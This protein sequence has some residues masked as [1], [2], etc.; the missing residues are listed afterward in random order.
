MNREMK[1]VDSR[2][3]KIQQ[4][5]FTNWIND[6][7]RG[8]LTKPDSPVMNLMTDFKDGIRLIDLM[9][10]LSKTKLSTNKTPKLKAHCLENLNAALKHIKKEG[11]TLVNIDSEDIHNGNEK[12]LLGLVWT[13]IRHYQIRS[14]GKG[15]STKKAMLMRVGAVIPEYNLQNLTTNW[16]DG[17]ALCGLVNSIKPG[18]CPNH[19]ELDPENGL[20]NCRLGMELAEENFNIPRILDPEDMNSKQID[21]LSMMT[22]LSYLLSCCNQGLLEWLQRQLPEFEITNLASDWNDGI[23]LAALIDKLFNVFPDRKDLDPER[24]ESNWDRLLPVIA[25]AT[26]VKCPLTAKQMS[27]PDI[28]ELSM[29]AFLA[30]LRYA[31][32]I[33]TPESFSFKPPTATACIG[34]ELRLQVQVMGPVDDQLTQDISVSGQYADGTD[35]TVK[36]AGIEDRSLTYGVAADQLGKLSISLKY[37]GENI[38]RSPFTVNVESLF[39]IEGLVELLN[40]TPRVGCPVMFKIKAKETPAPDTNINI[41]AKGPSQKLKTDISFLKENIFLCTLTPDEEGEY[42]VSIDANGHQIDGSPFC[43]N[44]KHLFELHIEEDSCYYVGIPFSITATALG[45]VPEGTDL[46]IAGVGQNGESIQGLCETM[47]KSRTFKLSLKP[48]HSGSFQVSV[49]FKDTHILG[50][51]FNLSVMDVY[52]IDSFL[53]PQPFTLGNSVQVKIVPLGTPSVEGEISI[54]GKGPTSSVPGTVTPDDPGFVCSF[55]PSETG[56]AEISVKFLNFHVKGSP[57]VLAVED[58]FEFQTPPKDETVTIGSSVEVVLKA[59]GNVKDGEDPYVVATDQSRSPQMGVVQKNED[60]TYVCSFTP[61]WIGI[62]EIEVKQRESVLKGTPI[63]VSVTHLLE[64]ADI[65]P[66]DISYSVGAPVKYLLKPLGTL[67]PDAEVQILGMGPKWE[68]QGT[69]IRNPDSSFQCSISPSE[70]G[71]LKVATKYMDVHVRGSPFSLGV[72]DL[73]YVGKVPPKFLAK[74]DEP[75]NF[76]VKSL[77]PPG[78]NTFTVISKGPSTESAGEIV[79]QENDSFF[80][81]ITPREQ[82]THTIHV[83]MDGQD[84]KGSP[85]NVDVVDASQCVFDKLPPS[86]VHIG[87]EIEFTVNTAKAGTGDLTVEGEVEEGEG[88]VSLVVQETDKGNYS[89]KVTGEAVGFSLIRILFSGDPIPGTPIKMGVVDAEKCSVIDLPSNLKVGEPVRF[90]LN[91]RGSGPGNPSV[92]FVGPD[93][94]YEPQITSNGDGTFW[95]ETHDLIEIGYYR[96]DIKFGERLIPGSP[97]NLSIEPAPTADQCHVTGN[98]LNKAVAGRPAKFKVL[99]TESGL[100]EREKLKVKVV[101]VSGGKKGKVKILDNKDKTYSAVYLCTHT[102]GY[103]IHVDF[104]DQPAPGSPFRINIVEGANATHVRAYGPALEPRKVLMSHTPQEFHVNA[105]K[106]GNGDLVVVIRGHKEDPKIYITDE[107]D[108]IFSVK[109]EVLGSGKYFAN[110]WWGNAHIP[111]S[112]FPLRI[113]P[114]PNPTMVKVHGPGIQ[115]LVNMQNAAHFTIETKE[116]GVGTLSVRVN[117]VKDAFTVEARP[118]SEVHPRTLLARYNPTCPGN[119]NIAIRWHGTHIP[120]SPF[121]VRVYDPDEVESEDTQSILEDD[122]R[123]L[124]DDDQYVDED[125]N[126]DSSGFQLSEDQIRLYQAQLKQKA[127]THN[128]LVAFSTPAPK[129]NPSTPS[130]GGQPVANGVPFKSD[131]ITPI[132]KTTPTAFQESTTKKK[133]WFGRSK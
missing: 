87:G 72:T 21:D 42:D 1:K 53:S 104:Y 108:N 124:L 85:L 24:A 19:R 14:T 107:G 114:R 47:E 54:V 35:T 9:E 100:V 116:A 115:R 60:D 132:R 112:P 129:T 44:V 64:V 95:V 71:P 81:V 13:L 96:M 98:G 89:V 26:E 80:V 41:V 45:A 3:K 92:V 33:F 62:W 122:S 130:Q 117:G 68:V 51:P 128:P 69:A 39:A 77:A 55:E 31:R 6:R 61:P 4:R 66:S 49:K 99:A 63:T 7:L 84:I 15:M 46:V 38:P 125:P 76:S 73:F 70:I 82:G 83:V 56:P 101:G 58:L 75:F 22:F 106:A 30:K 32:M 50:S 120:G 57:L 86:D 90:A 27:D 67:P 88:L 8:H 126:Y 74:V 78:E 11:I 119:Y 5:T 91:A 110:V 25:S 40:A 79:P 20:E 94:S 59:K 103:L 29:S 109:F 113:A 23:K 2:W 37:K 36:Y 65:P 121:S 127:A 10:K 17:R 34:K 48:N 52:K 93:K 118:M 131:Q 12:L 43:F 111:G 123:A 105:N 97:F 16:N 28:D 133:K 102:G 18:L